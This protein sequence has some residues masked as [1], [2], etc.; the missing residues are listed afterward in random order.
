MTNAWHPRVPSRGGPLHARITDTLAADI[1]E[2][3]LAPGT[4][5]PPQRDLATLLG[6]TVA[7]VTRSY[8]EAKRRGLVEATVGRGTFVKDFRYGAAASGPVDLSVS[9]LA[10]MPFAGELL[11]GFAAFVDRQAADALL[12]YQ[13][14]AGNQRHR[15]A[16]A[17][18]MA[19][20]GVDAP[21]SE[22]VVTAGGQHAMLVALAALT[23]PRDVLLVE[24]LTYTGVK[25]LANHLHLRV[26]GVDMDHEGLCPDALERALC[27]TRAR[28][29]YVMPT[30]NNPTGAVMGPARRAAILAVARAHDLTIIE[31]DQYGFLTDQPPLSAA[32]PERCCYI[33]S[34][35]KSVVAGIRVGF[36][37]VPAHLVPRLT[38]AIF[39]TAVMAP[40]VGA[41][42]MAR[43]IADG[44]AERIL[45]WK[46][47]EFAARQAIAR[48]V[49]GWRA[50]TPACPHVW[51]PIGPRMHVDDFVEQSRLRGVI[52]NAGAAF[53]AQPG[54][55]PQAVRICLGPPA[56][57]DVLERALRTLGDV[58]KAPPRPHDAM[59]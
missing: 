4:R 2:G 19:L 36:I 47:G 23:R 8:A 27:E 43:W 57:R 15:E 42:L 14:H 56:S 22:I 10:P 3:R 26:V 39:A 37:R 48:R 32:D 41:E 25:S 40:P 33:N 55:A 38:A 52:V 1:A 16:G 45:E 11:A 17:R 31:D 59:V 54:P 44:T 12:T 24:S 29:L 51:L 49:L 53:S 13:P 9:V 6:T 18:W 7:T 30:V 46:R 34:V 58:L 20:R 28:V 50:P 21:S 35:S 5:L